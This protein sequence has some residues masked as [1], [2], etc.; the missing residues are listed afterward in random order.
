MNSIKTIPE[1]LTLIFTT[2]PDGDNIVK[3]LLG[4]IT[5]AFLK[6]FVMGR[7]EGWTMLCFAIPIW[8][9]VR[10]RSVGRTVRMEQDVGSG[11]R[12]EKEAVGDLEGGEH[13]YLIQKK[14]AK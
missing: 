9:V 8:V 4:F 1:H 7:A 14:I 11:G 3:F 6:Y 10:W 12:E 2:F 5:V 13:N